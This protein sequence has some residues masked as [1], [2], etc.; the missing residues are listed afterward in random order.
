MNYQQT[1]TKEQ[2]EKILEN[3]RVK[4]KSMEPSKKENTY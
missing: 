1:M 2:K 3:K 4:Y